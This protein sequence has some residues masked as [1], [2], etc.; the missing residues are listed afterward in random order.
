MPEP[1]RNAAAAGIMLLLTIVLCAG[2]GA[3]VGAA[4]DAPELLAVGGGF[5]GLLLGFV[6]VYTRFKQ[7]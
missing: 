7:I 1:S 5:L 2:I 4:V 3:A 6:L